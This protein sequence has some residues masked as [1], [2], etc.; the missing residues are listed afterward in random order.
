[1]KRTRLRVKGISSTSQ[2]KDDIQYLVREIVIKRDGGC[3]LRHLRHCGGEIGQSVLQADHLVSRANSA[4]FADT[5]LIVCLCRPCH[6]GF[7]HW[8]EKEYDELVKTILPKDRLELWEKAEKDRHAHKT[9]K[10]DW[11]L[12]KV[13]LEKELKSYQPIDL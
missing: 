6:I 11:A 5:R 9:Y 8:H 12:E 4:T 13:C 10:M 3:I 2:L 7:K 1:M